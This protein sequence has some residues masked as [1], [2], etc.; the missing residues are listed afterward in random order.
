MHGVG[1][2]VSVPLKRFFA[3]GAAL[4]LAG[5]LAAGCGGGGGG[6]AVVASEAEREA[7]EP[8]PVRDEAAQRAEAERQAREEAARRAE[9]A[10]VAQEEAARRA[11]AEREAAVQVALADVERLKPNLTWNLA[12]VGTGDAYGNLVRAS[13]RAVRFGAGVTIGFIDTGIEPMHPAFADG[14]RTVDE[15]L[16]SGAGD[17][18]SD[19]VGGG[20][21]HG[22]AVASVAAGAA[23]GTS[24]EARQGV[25]PGA[26]VRMFAIQLGSGGGGYESASLEGL[27]GFSEGFA[28]YLRRAISPNVDVLNMSLSVSGLIDG[29]SEEGLRGHIARA[30]LE[31]AAQEGVQ[32]KTILVW[33]AGNLNNDPCVKVS[34]YGCASGFVDARSVAVT[35]GLPLRFPELHGHWVAAVAVDEDGTIADFSN[36][37]GSAAAFCIAAPGDYVPVAYFGNYEGRVVFG[38]SESRGTSF[39]VPTVAGG[40]AV[41]KQTFRGQLSGKA[42]VARLFA[43]ANKK[44]PYDDRSIYGQGLMDLAAATAPRSMM[45]VA[46]GD[47]VEAGG[48]ALRGT[49]LALGPAFGDGPAAALA[50]REIVAFDT[51][52]A[53][54]WFDLDG[55]V[56]AA[57]GP[58]PAARLRALLAPPRPHRATLRPPEAARVR[59][60]ARR[61]DRE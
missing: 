51:L 28:N 40:L 47:R 12:Q 58:A 19:F 2:T 53:P 6:G 30:F 25:A 49:G 56:G 18:L 8:P 59:V 39:A 23:R 34:D 21:S 11:R 5:A 33:A 27:K 57:R 35:A 31:A 60:F 26:N 52:G 44:P 9:A 22:T 14:A 36:R 37:C 38:E 4:A 43:T 32:D 3:V 13:G 61:G 42:L 41:M 20:Y 55:L 17:P 7:P 29:Y 46:A 24:P 15:V 48:A 54:F 10:R 1:R 45:T 50:G 16:L